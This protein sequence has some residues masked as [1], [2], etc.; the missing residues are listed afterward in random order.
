[1]HIKLIR[2]I[3]HKGHDEILVITDLPNPIYPYTGTLTLRSKTSRG[4][5]IEYAKK[6]FPDI[7]HTIT[8]SRVL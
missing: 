3:L 7:P 1:M 6:H 8:D 2:V 5:A 4:L